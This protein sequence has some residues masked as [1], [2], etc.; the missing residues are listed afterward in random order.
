MTLVFGNQ[1]LLLALRERRAMWRSRPSA[2]VAAACATDVAIAAALALSGTLMAALPWRLL[3]AV[4]AAAVGFA[5]VLDRLKAPV[6]AAFR[7][8]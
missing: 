4:F 5:L 1:A 6:M 2:W 3:V 7:V 8:A